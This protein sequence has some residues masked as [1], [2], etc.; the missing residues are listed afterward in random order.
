V[1]INGVIMGRLHVID[2]NLRVYIWDANRGYR[3]DKNVIFQF[4]LINDYKKSIPIYPSEADLIFLETSFDPIARIKRGKLYQK[5]T[6]G[7]TP[8][9]VSFS[10]YESDTLTSFKSDLSQVQAHEYESYLITEKHDLKNT[11]LYFGNRNIKMKWKILSVDPIIGHEE[12]C[13]L[14]EVNSVGAIPS[15]NKT[16]I[17]LDYFGEVESQYSSL[18]A[19]LHT[20]PESVID[21]C[22]DVVTSLLSAKLE[23]KKEDRPDLD[24]LIQ[25]ID[26]NLKIIKSSA[27]IVNRFHS[28]RKPNQKDRLSLPELSNSDSDFAVQAVFQI[29]KELKWN[30]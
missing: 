14:Q 10:G 21:H 9:M 30:L 20:S 15:L 22:R 27:E 3:V 5:N 28:R 12:V 4:V 1:K 17:P 24:K 7:G 8:K 13:V 2:S 23:L 29:I 16:A 11:F 19:E 26:E 18:L 25:R 6:Q